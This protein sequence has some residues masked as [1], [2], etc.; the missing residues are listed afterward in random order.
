[1]LAMRTGDSQRSSQPP[2]RI[3]RDGWTPER[4]LAFLTILARTRCISRAAAAAGMRRETAYRL[5]NRPA[6][7]LFAAA[8]DRILHEGHKCAGALG[9][10]RPHPLEKSPISAEGHE[11]NEVHNPR[12][13]GRPGK[14]L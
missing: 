10:A 1:M 6:G 3:R 4:Q 2:H 14:Q 8:W 12:S 9:G 11:G 7:A 5:R 13:R